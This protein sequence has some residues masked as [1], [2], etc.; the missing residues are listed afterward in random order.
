M[1]PTKKKRKV[2]VRKINKAKAK[3]KQSTILTIASSPNQQRRSRNSSLSPSLK[4]KTAA[5]SHPSSSKIHPPLTNTSFFSSIRT[6][7]K[8]GTDMVSE[9]SKNVLNDFDLKYNK[10]SQ[11]TNGGRRSGRVV[12]SHNRGQLIAAQNNDSTVD[13]SKGNTLASFH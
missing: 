7:T 8:D 10:K 1:S 6:Y 12:D 13:S 9:L 4:S 5:I 11:M 2:T 3:S